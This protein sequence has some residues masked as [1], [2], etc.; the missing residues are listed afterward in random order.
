MK[1]VVQLLT[2]DEAVAPSAIDNRRLRG[3]LLCAV[4]KAR[5]RLAGPKIPAMRDL[6]QSAVE[7]GE[8]VS[9]ENASLDVV[10][11]DGARKTVWRGGYYGRFIP[12]DG[13]RGHLVFV[14]GGVL[15]ASR[16]WIR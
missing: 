7:Q 8:K 5:Q 10:S 16:A 9:Y 14:H 2:S 6:V 11:R 15:Y 12:T 3:R 4:T 13:S 1:R